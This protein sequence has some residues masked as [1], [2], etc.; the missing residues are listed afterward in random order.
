M[1]FDFK[2]GFWVCREE[3]RAAD[4]ITKSKYGGCFISPLHVLKQ[5][6]IQE[7]FG[8][9]VKMFD[10]SRMETYSAN[11]VRTFLKQSSRIQGPKTDE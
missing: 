10:L 7:W 6:E 2:L 11:L 5:F 4:L 3:A 8:E 1:I 9:R